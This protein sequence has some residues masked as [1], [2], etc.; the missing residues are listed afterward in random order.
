MH[1]FNCSLL[2]QEKLDH[3]N[4]WIIERKQRLQKLWYLQFWTERFRRSFR[5]LC[6]LLSRESLRKNK[7]QNYQAPNKT[8]LHLTTNAMICACF[9][10]VEIPSPKPNQLNQKKHVHGPARILE[11]EET[12]VPRDI[13][14]RYLRHMW[15]KIKRKEESNLGY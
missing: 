2:F 10:V 11:N 6:S 9:W 8:T 13:L 4:V 5:L 3:W 14:L 7:R 15:G 12:S 1:R